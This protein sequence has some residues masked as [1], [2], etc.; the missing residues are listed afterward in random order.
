MKGRLF[1][2]S[3]VLVFLLAAAVDAAET[4]SCTTGNHFT[5]DPTTKSNCVVRGGTYYC[6]SSVLMSACIT[7]VGITA[8]NC[9]SW[10]GICDRKRFDGLS[11]SSGANCKSGLC[12]LVDATSGICAWPA[13]SPS[14]NEWVEVKVMQGTNVLAQKTCTVTSNK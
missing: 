12:T 9:V 2:I 13:Q 10:N 8:G 6:P 3:I 1:F 5:I 7:N 11:C 4:S 14:V